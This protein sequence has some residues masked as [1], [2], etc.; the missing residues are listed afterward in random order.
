MFVNGVEVEEN[1]IQDVFA[2]YFETKIEDL[3]AR[4]EL[5]EEVYNGTRK[6]H[7]NDKHFMKKADIEEAVKA[8][9]LKNSE[10]HDGIPQRL[11]IEGISILI[12]P[13]SILFDNVYMKKEIPEQW[14]MSKVIPVHK[15]GDKSTIKL[16]TTGST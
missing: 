10:G 2:D 11:L 1:C 9:K 5:N 13:L 4:V 15:K 3:M 12:K 6:I 16:T 8:I 14:K 7:I